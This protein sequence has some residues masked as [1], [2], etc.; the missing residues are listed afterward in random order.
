VQLVTFVSLDIFI[1]AFAFNFAQSDGWIRIQVLLVVSSV[2]MVVWNASF[3]LAIAHYVRVVYFF[4]YLHVYM[5][6]QKEPIS[7][8]N[9][10]HV[11]PVSPRAKL[12][13]MVTLAWPAFMA[14]YSIRKGQEINVLKVVLVQTAFILIKLITPAFINVRMIRMLITTDMCAHILANLLMFY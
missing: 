12:V 9:Q 5:N 10:R 3:R 11:L 13:V 2:S 1:T 8:I 14:I 7:I 4:I 6:A